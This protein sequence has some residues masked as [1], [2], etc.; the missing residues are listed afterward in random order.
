[1]I[2]ELDGAKIVEL[3]GAMIVGLEGAM[4]VGSLDVVLTTEDRVGDVLDVSS[5]VLESE[6]DAG[7]GG[8]LQL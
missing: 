1:M 4:I 5:M 6:D 2:V 7:G 8:M 3:G